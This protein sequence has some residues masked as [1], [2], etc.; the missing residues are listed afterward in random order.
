MATNRS[1]G[2]KQAV[3]L[4]VTVKSKLNSK[5][6][7]AAL[8]RIN[9]AIK[10]WIAA[11]K[12]RGIKTVLVAVDNPADKTLKK[13]RIRP[14]SGRPTAPKIKLVID[15]LWKELKPDNLVLFGACDVVPMFE[16]FNPAYDP[17]GD[18]DDKRCRPITLTLRLNAFVR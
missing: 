15:Q 8:G 2:K 5:Y 10:H 11:D 16:V 12:K 17:N 9:A 7:S 18:D 4:C 3:K 6:D 1:A 14:V 13:L